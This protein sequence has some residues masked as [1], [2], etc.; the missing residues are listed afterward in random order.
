MGKKEDVRDHAQEREWLRNLGKGNIFQ[1]VQQLVQ[2][3][4]S[5]KSDKKEDKKK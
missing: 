1:G 3:E 2:Q 4:K 5:E